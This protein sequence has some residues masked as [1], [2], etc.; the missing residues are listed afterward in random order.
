MVERDPPGKFG[1]T[2]NILYPRA[3]LERIDGFDEEMPAPAGED[4]ELLTRARRAGAA[5]VGAP[6]AITYHCVE[7]Y[8]LLGMLRLNRKWADIA[9]LAKTNPEIRS[10]F[11][12]RIFWRE[13][14]Y[15]LTLALAGL[16]L[17]R[18]QPAAALLA[19]PYLSFALEQRGTHARA[20]VA[21]AVELP[22]RLVIDLAE[23][24]TMVRASVRHR[25]VVI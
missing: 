15:R 6:D 13:T 24:A 18:R 12:H 7:S 4:L 23:I 8:S 19:L 16:A 20:R 9:Y 17:A 10:T 3:V 5:H 21:S 11:T 2:C 1:Q 25:T 14:H 22:G